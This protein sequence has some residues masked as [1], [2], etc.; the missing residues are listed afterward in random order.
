MFRWARAVFSTNF[1]MV[2]P[3]VKAENFLMN[4]PGDIADSLGVGE[5][6]NQPREHNQNSSLLEGIEL[7]IEENL[8]L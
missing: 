3:L 2:A 7:Q 6:Y 8:S 5:G 4:V 1:K